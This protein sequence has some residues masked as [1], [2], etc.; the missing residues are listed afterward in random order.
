V[1]GIWVP[2][3]YYWGLNQFIMQ[4]T[5]AAKNLREGQLGIIFAASLK[6]L[7]PFIIVMPGIMAVTLSEV[8][9][10]QIAADDAYPSMIKV[11]LPVGLRGFMWAALAGAVLSSLASMVNSASTIFTMDLYRRIMNREASQKRLVT[12]GRVMTLLFLVTACVIAPILNDPKFMGVY[13]FIQEFQGFFTPGILTAFVFGF[14]FKRAPAAAAVVGLAASPLVY[15]LMK[16]GPQFWLERLVGL[17]LTGTTAREALAVQLPSVG[18]WME[19]LGRVHDMAFLNRIAITF[20]L[21]FVLMGIVTAIRPSRQ[22]KTIPV[23][24]DFDMRPSRS[25]WTLGMVVIAITIFLY[26]Y[27]R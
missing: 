17:D 10:G 5:L 13:S 8:S 6:L 15:A 7:V 21:C 3:F 20:A 23:Q 2:N 11:L 22:P 9:G 14:I 19:F 24:Q 4:R 25:V 18:G 26:I 1:L 12:I 16:W 27:F